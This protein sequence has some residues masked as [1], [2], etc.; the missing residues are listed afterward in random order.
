MICPLPPMPPLPGD[1]YHHTARSPM[2]ARPIA[3]IA[4]IVIGWN[5]ARWLAPC[6]DSVLNQTCRPDEVV[7]VDDASTDDTVE[8]ARSFESDGLRIIRRETNGGMCAA[9]MTGVEA[10]KSTLLLFVDSD[11]VLPPDYLATMIEDLQSHAFVYPGKQFFGCREALARR[12][13]LTPTLRWT[14][15]EADRATLWQDNYADTCSLMRRSVLL[16]AGGW[17]SRQLDTWGDWDL[18]LRMSR[19]G[20]HARSRAMLNYR[21][22]DNNW[23]QRQE[24]GRSIERFGMVRKAAA[25]LSIATVYSGRMPGLW[26]EWLRAVKTALNSAG[27]T[28]ELIVI[29]A[30]PDGALDVDRTT[31]PFTAV[32]V[33]RSSLAAEAVARRL[34]RSATAEFLAAA[35]NE[36]L[37]ASTGDI[38][39]CIEDDTIV[40]P[41]ACCDMLEE[42][43]ARRDVRTAVG[44]L[45]RSRHQPERYVAGTDLVNGQVSHWRDAPAAPTPCAFTGCGCLMLLKDRLRGARWEGEWNYESRRCPAHDWT[46]A[47]SLYLRGDPVFIVPSVL[48]RHHQTEEVWV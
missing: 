45:Y 31:G 16:A 26:Y 20:T 35:F 13:K 5:C 7:F 11:N 23:S 33:R 15:P 43:L 29:D 40:P 21:V 34:D 28:A 36:A 19:L 30:S 8:I 6:L 25:T 32:Q 44:G 47:H 37:D 48:C 2:T 9:R 38:L 10:T 41:Q 1:Y 46:L 42:L 39:W 12:R 22:H 27:R 24:W 17:Q 4:L 3:S 18:F 14:P